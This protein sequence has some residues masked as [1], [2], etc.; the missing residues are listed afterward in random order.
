MAEVSWVT[1]DSCD[2]AAPPSSC[3][4]RADTGA[5]LSQPSPSRVVG[6]LRSLINHSGGRA[7]QNPIA[8]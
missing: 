3:L 7:F 2:L 4:S 1:R 5:P 8:R 6:R